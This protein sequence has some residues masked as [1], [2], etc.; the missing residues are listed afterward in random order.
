MDEIQVP[1]PSDVEALRRFFEEHS[2]K[3]T[4][5]LCRMIGRSASTIRNWRRNCGLPSKPSPFANMARPV[6]PK[7]EV[8]ALPPEVWDNVEWFRQAYT[9]KKWGIPT[10]ARQIGHG[11][12]FVSSRLKRYN[13]QT[14]KHA[15]SCASKNECC[16]EQWLMENY[17]T[18]QQYLEWAQNKGIE[19]SVECGRGYS[20]R[21][22]A[23]VAGVTP[24]T[25]YNW[26]AKF[27]ISTRNIHDAM[28]GDLNPLVRKR[29]QTPDESDPSS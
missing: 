9:D 14:R 12:A 16:S 2:D 29:K 19:P 13:I 20:I 4:Y 28:R 5:D 6:K 21:K 17:A 24:Y 11:V 1:N 22:C 26:L 23:R 10:I 15:D 8:E 3:S 18:K 27:K 25:V 7:E